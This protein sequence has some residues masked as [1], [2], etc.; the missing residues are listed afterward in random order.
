MTACAE[1]VWAEEVCQAGPFL[2]LETG[3]VKGVGGHDGAEGSW[4]RG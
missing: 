4:A 2:R 1:G 3:L